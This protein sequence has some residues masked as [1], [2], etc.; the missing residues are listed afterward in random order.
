M[1]ANLDAYLEEISHYLFLR[2]GTDD[3]LA[4]I[5]SHILEKAGH[6]HGDVSE[7]AV[8]DVISGY[9]SPQQVAA[10]YMEGE[11]LI[12]PTLKRYLLRY[13]TILF[14]IHVALTL[15]AS[16]LKTSLV[17]FPFL[18]IPPLSSANGLFYLPTAF[19]YDLGLAGIFLY[20]VTRQAKDV[21]LPWFNIRSRLSGATASHESEP[22]SYL[23]ILML[24]GFGAVLWVYLRF[25]TLFVMGIGPDG[26]QPLFSP[27]VSHWY[28]LAVLALVAV[29]I[30]GYVARFYTRSEWI[31]A[32]TSA[33]G[34][35]IAGI[36]S[37][38]PLDEEPS[39][40]PF[41]SERTFGTV[42][43]LIVAV[44]NALGLLSSLF[45]IAR[46]MLAGAIAGRRS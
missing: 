30:G 15:A 14:A 6:E 33:L 26:P 18:Y 17:I 8:A 2:Q 46:R 37:I 11:T 3:V 22:K 12:A 9:G 45:R 23:L 20:F 25:Q 7:E 35:M 5:R 42:F 1:Y 24:M 34:L 39:R 31:D 28:S 21:N 29:G 36:V 19:I 41:L 16:L 4:E 43:V 44:T 40:L 13:A 10:R 38:Y 32:A 27:T